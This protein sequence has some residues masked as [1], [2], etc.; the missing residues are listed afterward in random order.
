MRVS[1]I[2]IFLFLSFSCL[3]AYW[4]R[5]DCLEIV[6]HIDSNLMWQDDC[7]VKTVKKNWNDAFEYCAK[8]DFAGY[9]D[10]SLPSIDNLFLI[11]NSKVSPS[12]VGVFKNY[13]FDDWYWSSTP[14]SSD[15]HF[16][17]IGF[18]SGYD[19]QANETDLLYVRCVRKMN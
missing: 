6:K 15:R 17:V 4:V 13:A 2:L 16:F 11:V 8:L 12:I 9:S 5:D 14:Y 1:K 3:S 7:S 10:W 18:Y 19:S